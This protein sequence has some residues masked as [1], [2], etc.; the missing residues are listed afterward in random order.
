VF[1]EGRDVHVIDLHFSVFLMN[2]SRF[3]ITDS[4]RSVE[5]AFKASIISVY[6]ALSM[7]FTLE[8]FT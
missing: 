1:V 6:V 4:Q 8:E 7:A 5:A 3:F 2:F